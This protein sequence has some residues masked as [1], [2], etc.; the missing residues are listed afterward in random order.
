MEN[1]NKRFAIIGVAGYIALRHLKAIKSLGQNVVSAHD[2]FDSVGVIDSYFLTL[3]SLQT[4]IRLCIVFMKIMLITLLFV[5]Q[6]I[7]IVLIHW[8]DLKPELMLYAKTVGFN[9]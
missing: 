7:C 9:L 4:S 1:I 3:I 2:L 5:R 6:T 8:Q